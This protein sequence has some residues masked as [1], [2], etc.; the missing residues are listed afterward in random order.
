MVLSWAGFALLGEVLCTGSAILAEIIGPILSG[1]EL[2][3]GQASLAASIYLTHKV[4]VAAVTK[5]KAP[6][7]LANEANNAM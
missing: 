1:K 2:A 7:L 6:G 3:I 4:T 5:A